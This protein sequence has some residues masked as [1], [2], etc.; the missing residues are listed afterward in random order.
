MKST[1]QGPINLGHTEKYFLKDVAD[2]VTNIAESQ[3]KIVYK[4]PL[5]YSAKQGVPNIA[6]AKEKLGWFPVVDLEEGL[7][8]TIEFMKG[9]KSMDFPRF[10]TDKNN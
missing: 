10:E 8:K 3:A 6:L 7:E 9:S 4:P 2:K 5:A 1:E